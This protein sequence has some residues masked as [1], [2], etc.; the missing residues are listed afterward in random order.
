MTMHKF[1]FM[2]VVSVALVVIWV[3][4]YVQ[5][6]Y[7]LHPVAYITTAPLWHVSLQVAWFLSIWV[8]AAYGIR[9]AWPYLFKLL[10]GTQQPQ[11]QATEK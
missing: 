10:Q 5:A 2:L 9:K 4:T 8:T 3:L 11:H 1:S 7:P 6:H